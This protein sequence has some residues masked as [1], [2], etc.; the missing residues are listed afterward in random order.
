MQFI[1]YAFS[2]TQTALI[3]R[4]G[5]WD[6]VNLTWRVNE[7]Q[8]TTV[9]AVQIANNKDYHFKF[10]KTK[11][12]KPCLEKL[13][14][15]M[16]Q[17]KISK[18]NTLTKPC[19]ELDQQNVQSRLISVVI[20]SYCIIRIRALLHNSVWSLLIGKPQRYWKKGKQTVVWRRLLWLVK[21]NIMQ[22]SFKDRLKMGQLNS[23]LPAPNTWIL[24]SKFRVSSMDLSRCCPLCRIASLTQ[25]T[26][27]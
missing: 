26:Q 25:L 12:T 1:R 23:V 27:V 4:N 13:L 10:S 9:F 15:V 20:C 2:F 24:R 3:S 21:R 7:L 8:T 16:L 5:W 22:G 6:L 17:L 11:G 19:F 18:V 14:W